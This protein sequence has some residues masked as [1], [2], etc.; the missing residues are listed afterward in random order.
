MRRTLI[1]ATLVTVEDFKK[2]IEHYELD[3]KIAKELGDRAGEGVSYGDLGNAYDSK[4]DFK[5]AIKYHELHLEIAKELGD[6]AG[7][8]K[9]YG[10][11][12]NAYGS[13]GDFQKAIKYHELHLKVMPKKW[14]RGLE[15]GYR[16]LILA[17]LMTVWEISRKPLST[18]N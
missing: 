7:E 5:T 16:M 17:L 2:A 18:M 3:L 14:E 8:G 4:G 6:R 9:S 12:G 1:L 10:N 13:L 11:L 15:N